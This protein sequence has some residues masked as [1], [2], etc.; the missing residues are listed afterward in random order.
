MHDAL[1]NRGLDRVLGYPGIDVLLRK[2][3]RN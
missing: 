2:D 3:E 1:V